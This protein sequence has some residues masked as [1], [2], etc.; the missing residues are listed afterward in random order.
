MV[1]TASITASKKGD[2]GDAPATVLKVAKGLIYRLEVEFP[3]GCCGLVHVQ[4]FDGSYQVYPATPEETFHSNA[5]VIGFDDCYLKQVA[6]F[7]FKISIW[8]DD[9]CWPHTIQVRIGMAS[10]EAFMARYMPGLTWKKFQETL[11]VAAIEERSR[12][13]GAIETFA[14]EVEEF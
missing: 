6:P 7:E 8:N 3:P 2:E 4:I 1:Y 13:E 5:R 10:S 12:R 9:E 11:A 14:K